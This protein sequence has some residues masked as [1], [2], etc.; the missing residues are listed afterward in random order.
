MV[1][2]AIAAFPMV[3]SVSAAAPPTCTDGSSPQY[4]DEWY[5]EDVQ[6][7]K[8]AREHPEVIDGISGGAGYGMGYRCVPDT[9]AFTLMQRLW[10]PAVIFLVAI[11]SVGG[12]IMIKNAR[13]KAGKGHEFLRA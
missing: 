3:S 6:H 13:A 5:Q 7:E 8:Y 11:M 4:K 10:V 1:T 12:I 9:L 2:L